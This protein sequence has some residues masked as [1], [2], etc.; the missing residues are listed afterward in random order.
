MKKPFLILFLLVVSLNTYSQDTDSTAC[1]NKKNT[2]RW[3]MTPIFVIGPKSIVL[4]YERVINPHQTISINVGYLE[5]P[6]FTD[7]NDNPVYLFQESKNWGMDITLDYRFYFK[8]RNKRLAPD[9]VYWGPYFAYYNLNFEGESEVIENNVV[10]N[11]IGV[12]MGVNMYS[13]GV[14]VGYQFVIA[15][16]FTVDLIFMGPSY[17][18]YNFEFQF[19]SETELDKDSDFYKEIIPIIEKIYPLAEEVLSGQKI[20]GSGNL[21]FNYFGFRYVIQVGYRF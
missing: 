17:T 10:S 9:G 21:D 20:T 13:L 1:S 5:K 2:I 12:E 3:N 8:N 6:P 16:R 15:D 14:Q 18:R 4:G 11:T 7:E 19:N